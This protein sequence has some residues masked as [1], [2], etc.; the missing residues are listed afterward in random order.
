MD[1]YEIKVGDKVRVK[2]WNY[3]AEE[4]KW[5]R[6]FIGVEMNVVSV[7]PAEMRLIAA[8]G[9]QTCFFDKYTLF[10]LVKVKDKGDLVI[11]AQ[12]ATFPRGDAKELTF[13]WGVLKLFQVPEGID[14]PLKWLHD[15]RFDMIQKLDNHP[16]NDLT[17]KLLR[18][19]AEG[20][21]HRAML[22]A[23]EASTFKDISHKTQNKVFAKD[24]Q[25][26]D[27]LSERNTLRR[28]NAELKERIR[29]LERRG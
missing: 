11:Q 26:I 10:A 6:E 12:Q 19:R 20:A 29:K 14:D 16:G 7:S 5:L 3:A 23:D 25:L 15:W 4:Q 9:T 17:V 28:Q 2:H 8:T 13:A 1:I 21:E 22:A 24:E 27:V 18:M